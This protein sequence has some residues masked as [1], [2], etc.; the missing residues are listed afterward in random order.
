MLAALIWPG[1]INRAG[2]RDGQTDR[3][4]IDHGPGLLTWEQV[5]L[6]AEPGRP[7]VLPV[8]C[9][10][11]LCGCGRS[12][13]SQESSDGL[14]RVVVMIQTRHRPQLSHKRSG[15]ACRP[16]ANGRTL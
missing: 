3:L 10:P 13:W 4:I 14:L 12:E 8:S 11:E 16:A 5:V 2:G 7:A 6:H 1:I 15:T 9:Y